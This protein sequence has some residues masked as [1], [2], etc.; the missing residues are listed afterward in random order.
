MNTKKWKWKD[1]QEQNQMILYFSTTINFLQ[2]CQDGICDKMWRFECQ[3]QKWNEYLVE[4]L[5][6][7]RKEK[8]ESQEK[9]DVPCNSNHQITNRGLWILYCHRFHVAYMCWYVLYFQVI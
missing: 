1:I 4:V 3:K 6:V 2:F 9:S 5:L 7:L 8:W